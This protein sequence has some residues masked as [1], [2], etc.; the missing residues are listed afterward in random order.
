MTGHQSPLLVLIKPS[1]LP[2]PLRILFPNKL[3]FP[4]QLKHRQCLHHRELALKSV[5]QRGKGP[6]ITTINPSQL[7][8][9]NHYPRKGIPRHY[10]IK[11]DKGRVFQ[12]ITS[13]KGDQFSASFTT[14]VHQQAFCNEKG[15]D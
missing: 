12:L 2:H 14:Q 8:I 11:N 7:Q 1:P 4:L 15:G 3:P 5:N 13:R 10:G 6:Q 9:L